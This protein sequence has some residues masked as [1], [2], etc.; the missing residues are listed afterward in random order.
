MKITI[1][2]DELMLSFNDESYCVLAVD[3][4]VYIEN[5]GELAG[6]K[7]L[8]FKKAVLKLMYQDF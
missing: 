3:D 2:D 4:N 1:S 6:Y 8:E 5:D 7:A